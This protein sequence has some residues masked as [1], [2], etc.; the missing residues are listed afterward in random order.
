[1]AP[2]ENEAQG[3]ITVSSTVHTIPFSLGMS[4]AD[5]SMS[6]SHSYPSRSEINAGAVWYCDSNCHL[7]IFTLN[8][9][10]N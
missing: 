1:M 2:D 4:D 5:S 7:M 3:L 6:M 10:S 9:L 8:L